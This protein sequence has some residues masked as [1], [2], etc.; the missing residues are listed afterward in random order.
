MTFSLDINHTCLEV[1]DLD[2]VDELGERVQSVGSFVQ[3][4]RLCGYAIDDGELGGQRRKGSD[5]SSVKISVAF[6]QF[7]TYGKSSIR[8]PGQCT[9]YYN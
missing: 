3:R 4:G 2:A 7:E 1:W 6:R 8:P 5:A 9:S